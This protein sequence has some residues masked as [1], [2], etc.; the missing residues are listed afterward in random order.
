MQK[1]KVPDMTCGHC[2]QTVETAIKRLDP[3]ATVACDLDHKEVTVTTQ[4][5]AER[6]AAALADVGFESEMLSA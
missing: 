5:A 4:I 3:A 2:V 1:F 6:I